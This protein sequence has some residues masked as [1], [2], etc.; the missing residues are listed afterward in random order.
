MSTA[1]LK[2]L[3]TVAI[4][5]SSFFAIRI[6]LESATP[7][8]VV[9]VRNAVASLLLFALVRARGGPLLPAREDRP[10]CLLLGLVI[11]AHFLIQT[12]AMRSTSTLHAG[13]II[14]FIPV[15]VAVGSRVFLGQ[16]MKAAGWLGIAIA[17]LGVLALT[18]ARPKELAH[19]GLGDGLMLLSTVTWAA[20]TLLAID[21]VRRNGGLRVA[22][23][24]L[25]IAAVPTLAAA[26][27]LGTWHA[28]PS[29]RSIAAIAFLSTCA[30]A[31]AMWL[32]ADV[33]AELGPER[34]S[35]FQYLQP[36]V[37]LA[38]S[39]LFLD[40]PSTTSQ[41]VAGPA[42]LVGVW[43]VQRAKRA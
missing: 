10:R 6:A 16:R 18:A 2:A 34:S 4:W 9:G 5:G 27:W 15:V 8:G 30:S 22:A 42:V 41:L 24:A 19:A 3:A 29:L 40:E 35:A 13:W 38:V 37:T 21:V 32:F 7:L 43:L 20:Y 28:E 1:V 11:S 23:F 31:L 25:G 14:A 33:V 12:F 36:F 39:C 26:L 17:T